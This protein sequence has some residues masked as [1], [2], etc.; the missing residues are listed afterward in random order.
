MPRTTEEERQKRRQDLADRMRKHGWTGELAR[1]IAA[2]YGVT[3]QT[4]YGDKA[5]VLDAMAAEE[6]T[7]IGP[8]RAGW[9]LDVR[10]ARRLAEA[11]GSW[12]TVAR[13]LDL[14]GKALGLDK[15]PLPTVADDDEDLDKT[16]EGVLAAV[17]ELRKRAVAGNSFVA[18]ERLI[19]REAELAR[20][21]E[22]REAR[23]A[24]EQM[25]S[26]SLDEIVASVL[27]AVSGL[28]DTLVRR[29]RD[30]LEES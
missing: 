23:E 4:V 20:D 26:M 30:E 25:E 13:L 8:R 19:G 5:A 28:P 17:R 7:A 6:T 27:D 14:E 16:L 9:L 15:A 2:E 3:R 24:Q 11:D 29:I 18:A 1:A 10:R 12:N 21:I 22:A